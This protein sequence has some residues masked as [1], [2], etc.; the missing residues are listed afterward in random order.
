M[1][2]AVIID[3]VRTPGGK[4]NGKLEG[5][6][7]AA[8]DAHVPGALAE[9]TRLDPALVDELERRGGRYG[10]QVMCEGGGMANATLIER[11]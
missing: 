5:W 6:H 11:I 2:E 10:L 9:R 4:R 3:A 1:Q 8:L 7:P